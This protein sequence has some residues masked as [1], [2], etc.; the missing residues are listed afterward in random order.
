MERNVRPDAWRLFRIWAGIG[1]QSFGGGSSTI[2]LIQR[3]FIDE[4]K[5]ITMEDYVRLWN[6]CIF[7]PGINLVALTVLIG[8]ILGGYWGVVASLAG[9]LLPS[10]T[11]TC[12]LTAG[13]TLIERVQAVQAILR[14]V[15]PA[16]AGVMLL[17]AARYLPD[18][19]KRARKEGPVQLIASAAIILG[20]AAGIIV[21]KLNI[22]L[23]LLL[24][25]LGGIIFFTSW[26]AV[27]V[28]AREQ[29]DSE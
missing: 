23:V 15:I 6:L 11:I 8:R 3:A 17:V 16:T 18:L 2:F 19:Y 25:A 21:L 10:G 22:I 12:L 7:T 20:C 29:G 1:L 14:G 28:Q 26:R 4:Y 24:A 13:F 27:D 9:L 5:W